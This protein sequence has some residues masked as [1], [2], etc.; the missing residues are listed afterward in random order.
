MSIQLICIDMDGTL[1]MDDHHVS[2]ED[3]AAIKEA[4]NQGVH[5]AITTGRVYNCAKLYAKTIGL[6][7]PIIASNGAFIGG[8]NGETIYENP[9]AIEDVRD[10]LDITT[11]HGL[12]A[13]LTANFGIVSMQELPE[14]N[15]YKVLNKTLSPQEQIRLEVLSSLDEIYGQYEGEIL[16]G[17]CLASNATQLNEVKDEIKA[18]CPHLEVV[19]SWKN[20]F[21][22]MKK[23]SS[24]GAAV[25]QLAA[26]FNLKPE[27]V[28]CIGDSENDLSMIEFAGIG[29]AMGNAMDIVKNA[30]DYVTT[31][32]T[33][34]GVANAIKKFVLNKA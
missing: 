22:V 24:K 34:A 30:A 26:F 15:I 27:E 5:V 2:V 23:G 14:T 20:N 31:S 19:S 25:A 21:E 11:S 8:T 12:L 28:M 1:L 6:E 7:T 18:K 33:E 16:K 10:F 32:N 4:V 29:V 17:V 3:Q 13:Y 9:L